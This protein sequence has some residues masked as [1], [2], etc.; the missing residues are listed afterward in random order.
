[1]YKSHSILLLK[2]TAPIINR[3][4]DNI[5][6]QDANIKS[7]EWVYERGAVFIFYNTS[8]KC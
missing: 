2:T 4:N 3:E 7:T 1:M 6:M 8:R 5:V